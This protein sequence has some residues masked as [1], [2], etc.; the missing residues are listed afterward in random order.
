MA[1]RAWGRVL[2]Q[3]NSSVSTE[4]KVTQIYTCDKM[5]YSYIHIV[6]IC[7][8]VLILYYSNIKI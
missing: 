8:L 6:T 3:W 2:W 4:V 5:A 7:F 1:W